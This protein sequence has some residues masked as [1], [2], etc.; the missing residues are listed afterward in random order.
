MAQMRLKTQRTYGENYCH[1]WF[2][3][4]GSW[5]RDPIHRLI[6]CELFEGHAGSYICTYI[7][8]YLSPSPIHR[9][10]YMYD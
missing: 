9:Q 4:I 2:T 7:Y 3:Q 5:H 10:I 8:V 6:V 1:G